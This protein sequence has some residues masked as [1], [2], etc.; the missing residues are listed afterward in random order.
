MTQD[1]EIRTQKLEKRLQE[2]TTENKILKDLLKGVH[3]GS[4]SNQISRKNLKLENGLNVRDSQ[5]SIRE[6][7]SMFGK[8][9]LFARKGEGHKSI[10]RA[11]SREISPLQVSKSKKKQ[12]YISVMEQSIKGKK[13][14]PKNLLLN[15]KKI[16]SKAKAEVTTSNNPVKEFTKTEA[17]DKEPIVKN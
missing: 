11:K 10:P 8:T 3:S 13:G 4:I 2:S 15:F 5:E 1:L 7:D 9:D 16:Y 6:K 17:K 12:Q 14:L